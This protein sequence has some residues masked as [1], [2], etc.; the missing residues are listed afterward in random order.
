L[1]NNNA[2][3]NSINLPGGVAKYSIVFNYPEINK[4]SLESSMI[5]QAYT[6]LILKLNP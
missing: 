6:G 4:P 1:I 5:L 2:E 3:S